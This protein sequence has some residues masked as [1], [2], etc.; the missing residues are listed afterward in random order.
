M[1]VPIFED[2]FFASSN[3]NRFSLTIFEDGNDVRFSLLE[4][5]LFFFNASSYSINDALL[6]QYRFRGNQLFQ[7][8][9]SPTPS[10]SILA[11]NH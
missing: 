4:D 11:P 3:F 7:F 9:L 8:S 5:Y 6:V 10:V 2:D 1:G